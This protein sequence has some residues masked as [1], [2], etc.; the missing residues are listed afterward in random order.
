MITIIIITNMRYA[1]SLLLLLLSF[2]FEDTE[3][4]T[5]VISTDIKQMPQIYT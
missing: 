3:A 2:R 5:P 1:Y 4:L